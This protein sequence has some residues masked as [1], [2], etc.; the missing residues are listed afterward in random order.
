MRSLFLTTAAFAVAVALPAF[1]QNNP[2]G[3]SNGYTQNQQYNSGQQGTR[4]IS[5]TAA[6]SN[7]ASNSV[8][9]AQAAREITREITRATRGSSSR[10]AHAAF[11]RR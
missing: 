10:A 4:R 6:V 7:T 5:R 2:G 1:A 8:R 11:I 9:T 3:S